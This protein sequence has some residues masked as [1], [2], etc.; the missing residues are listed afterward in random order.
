MA[1]VAPRDEMGDF[2]A[3]VSSYVDRYRPNDVDGLDAYDILER[4]ALPSYVASLLPL[5]KNKAVRDWITTAIPTQITRD[6]NMADFFDPR[7]DMSKWT[8]R[9][10]EVIAYLNDHP[11][12]RPDTPVTD[13]VA[14]MRDPERHRPP[15]KLRGRTETPA[16]K[17]WFGNSVVV[18]KLGHPLVV[19]RGTRR[20][21]DGTDTASETHLATPSFTS[22]PEIA[23]V[24]S[25]SSGMFG[26]HVFARGATVAPYY[27]SIQK[28]I[29]FID[30]KVNLLDALENLVP[31]GNFSDDGVFDM[32]VG[33]LTDLQ[34][35]Q[36]DFH[37]ELPSTGLF[38]MDWDDVFERLK[39]MQRRH[40][41]EGIADFLS[42]IEVDSYA[43]AD[44]GNL[45]YWAME[46]GFDGIVHR[47]VFGSA[48]RSAMLSTIGKDPDEINGL[49]DDD[50]VSTH[51]TYRPFRQRQIKSVFNN[52]SFDQT[53]SHVAETRH[54]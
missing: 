5:A 13:V 45:V 20:P 29:T 54:F 50:D 23:S 39:R 1:A 3:M 22:V 44:S 28:P 24:Y 9:H 38:E 17:A 7:G 46:R 34:E 14:A 52:G 4:Y 26:D 36:D 15:T 21:G 35:R 12:G 8:D 43:V 37:L 40:R 48:G 49:D 47:D 53:K 25:S 2:L 19:F 41:D 18:D 11:P 51:L 6:L 10:R 33:V 27:L 32:I 16:F 42:Q 31:E 30:V